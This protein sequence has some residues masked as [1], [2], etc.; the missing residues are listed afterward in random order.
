MVRISTV[1]A[2]ADI[3]QKGAS[4]GVGF[5]LQHLLVRIQLPD[6]SLAVLSM[7]SQ[8]RRA[9]VWICTLPPLPASWP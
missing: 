1:H 6:S 2:V 3:C 4:P 9:Q 5:Y 8:V 7:G